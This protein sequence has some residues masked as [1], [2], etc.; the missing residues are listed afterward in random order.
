MIVSFAHTLGEF[1]VVLMIGGSVAG[2]TKV[3]SVAI[4][5]AVELLDYHLAHIYS[6]IMLIISFSVLFAVY[7][8]NRK[9]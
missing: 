6:G 8:I 1:G 9:S 7:F 2:Q 5:D 4:Y 3:A